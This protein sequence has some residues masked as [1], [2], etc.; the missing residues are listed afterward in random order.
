MRKQKN[1][2]ARI[3]RKISLRVRIIEND[4]GDYEVQTREGTFKR[5][6]DNAEWKPINQFSMYKR[7][8]EKKQSYIVMI[9]MRELGYR[10]EFV[11]RRTERKKIRHAKCRTNS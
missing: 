8:L 1:L 7:A 10:N 2:N 4:K 11:K 9:L 5:Q 3:L 6:L